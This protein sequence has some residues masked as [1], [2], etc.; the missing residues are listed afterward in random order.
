MA[1]AAV[2]KASDVEQRLILLREP[3]LRRPRSGLAAVHCC[4]PSLYNDAR[5]RSSYSVHVVLAS[6]VTTTTRR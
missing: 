1:V 6:V 2:N 3:I 5:S 4:V